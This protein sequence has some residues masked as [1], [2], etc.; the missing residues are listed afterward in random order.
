MGVRKAVLNASEKDLAIDDPGPRTWRVGGVMWRPDLVSVLDL[1]F[2]PG[3][4]HS[5]LVHNCAS[6]CCNVLCYVVNATE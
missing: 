4:S 3:P 5:K 2:V 6:L 1:C